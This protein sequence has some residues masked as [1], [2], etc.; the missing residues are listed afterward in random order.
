MSE[1]E[2]WGVKEGIEAVSERKVSIVGS[3]AI[4]EGTRM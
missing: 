1:V 4:T 2:I 3:S